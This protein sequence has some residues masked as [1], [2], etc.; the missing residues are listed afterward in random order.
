VRT[1]APEIKAAATAVVD[2]E[3]VQQEVAQEIND[4]HFDQYIL[5]QHDILDNKFLY[6]FSR[7]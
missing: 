6:K 3:I 5:N 1:A 7:K 4:M 2:L